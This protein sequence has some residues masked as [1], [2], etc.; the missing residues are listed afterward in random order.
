MVSGELSRLLMI[1]MIS[2]S[3]HQSELNVDSPVYLSGLQLILFRI[4][5]VVVD[6]VVHVRLQMS[7]TVCINGDLIN[8]QD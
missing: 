5:S 4:L 6:I 3:V 2:T 1:F 8:G 7:V